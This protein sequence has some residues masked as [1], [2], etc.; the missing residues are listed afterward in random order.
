[1]NF[2]GLIVNIKANRTLNL[3]E[4]LNVQW[5]SRIFHGNLRHVNL[6]HSIIANF[7][8]LDVFS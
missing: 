5:K 6:Q 7:P 4:K 3:K 1:M 2:L 8:G